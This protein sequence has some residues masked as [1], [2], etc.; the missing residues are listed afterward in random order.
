MALAGGRRDQAV[1]RIGG[2]PSVLDAQAHRAHW[3]A[4]WG[5]APDGPE[6]LEDG[7]PHVPMRRAGA[8]AT[9]GRRAHT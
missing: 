9:D 5:Y 1:A 4:R 8:G 3:D 6:F 2:R 7:I